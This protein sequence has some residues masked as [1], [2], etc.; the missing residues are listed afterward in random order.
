M[1]LAR[2]IYSALLAGIAAG[3]LLTSLQL[4]SLQPIILAAE[5]YEHGFDA[6]PG[7]DGGRA[8]HS[9][10]GAPAAGAGRI[11]RTLVANLL[12]STGFAAV[13]LALMCLS[14]LARGRYLSW[15]QGALWGLAGYAALFVAPAIGLPPEIPGI[16]AAPVE[17]RQLWWLLTA[18]GVSIGL[19]IL[20]FA[21]ARTKAVGI[22]FVALPYI[23]GAPGGDGVEFAHSNPAVVDE[24]VR[25]HQ[26]FIVSSAIVNLVFWLVLG[27]VCRYAFNRWLRAVVPAR[28]RK[29]D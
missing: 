29:R 24:L 21:P 25:L 10:G 3:V 2:I 26:R 27:L 6:A 19:A 28:D 17:H 13:L 20:G 8:E 23:V 14:R 7:Q 15:S 9:H 4:A 5:R 1:I 18:L 22:L 12:A 11:A 16:D